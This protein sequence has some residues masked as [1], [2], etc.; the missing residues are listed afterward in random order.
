MT[1][2]TPADVVGRLT[3][4]QK[5]RLVGGASYWTTT[6]LPD[7]PA[8]YLADGPHGVRRLDPAN[9]AVAGAEP[10]TCF[11]PAVALGATFDTALAER[12]G[13]AIG[14]EAR[15]R[16]V[17]VVLGPG[18]N[19]KRSPLCGRNFE[20]VSED[21]L[22]GGR[23]GA[24]LVRGIQSAGVGACVKHFVAN[25]QE[26]ERLRVSADI[27]ERTLREVHL[28]PFQHVVTEARPW[29]VMSSYNRV[30]GTYVGE[31]ARLLTGV[32][33]DEWGFDG[34]VMSDWVAVHD[35]VAA[36]RAGLDLEMPAPGEA[37][38]GQIVEA[39]RSGELAEDDLDRAAGRV[40]ALSRKIRDTT[41]PSDATDLVDH[42]D[43][44][45]E[46]A[47]H[48]IVL[49]RNEPVGDTDADTAAPLL[50]LASNARVAVV[51]E[52]ARTPRYQGAGSSQVV[53][54]RLDDALTALTADFP[55][56]AFAPGYAL[57]P[58]AG[59]DTAL[60]AE[61]VAEASDAD[62]VLFFAGLPDD[63]EAEGRD[64]THIDLPPVQVDLLESVLDVNPR[65]VVVLSNGS[66][67]RLPFADRV[68]ALVEGWLLG[69]AGGS[70]V[71]DVLT[72]RVNPSGRLSE[73]IPHRLAD[74]PAYLD[75]PGEGLHVR[76]AEGVFVGHRWYDA[77]D[78][79]V[80]FPF[81]HGLSYTTF[82]YDGLTT[83]T[84][85]DE[86]RVTLT[87]TNTGDVPGREV[88]QCYL[89]RDESAVARPPRVLAAFGVVELEPGESRRV[90]LT[91]PAADLAHWSVREDAWTTEGGTWRVEVGASS[92]DIRLTGEAEITG[93]DAVR[94][95]TAGSTL[96][97]AIAD[98]TVGPLVAGALTGMSEDVREM[99]LA[100]PVGR[101]PFVPD[102]GV[103]EEQLDELI[104]LSDG[105]AGRL[106]R[107]AAKVLGSMAR[108]RHGAS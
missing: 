54:T 60:A 32:L 52:L 80:A 31:D 86:L 73:T 85:H 57:G 94:P 103:S 58:D 81:G 35:R 33:R 9:G 25:D 64:R 13:A 74:T 69:Q 26:T 95:I 17:G 66:V 68:P 53:P 63:A 36:L 78:L 23:I 46:A 19:V 6:E 22:L 48:A 15:E 39:I 65:M 100:I 51:G 59:D 93:D 30:N 8:A 7:V 97:E 88:V 42:H 28:R 55:D 27:D 40:V 41:T 108:R 5:A 92:R 29:T 3:I 83:A 82:G 56:V 45:R 107:T 50:P 76:Y 4:E 16:D 37:R 2:V 21:P 61:A 24:A 72:G 18:V 12:V 102:S 38:V 43:L 71:A 104:A 70:A 44:A 84:H 96:R 11:P 98:P 20:Y 101:M 91:V 49:L 67:V 105:S 79:D 90:E 62:V 34:L 106:R 47:A 99:A 75:F 1:S 89:G 14:A 87:V 77:R 10:A